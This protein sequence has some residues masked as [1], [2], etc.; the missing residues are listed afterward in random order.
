M[1]ALRH[2]LRPLA[3]LFLAVFAFS[4]LSYA[5]VTFYNNQATWSANTTDVTNRDFNNINNGSFLGSGYSNN[6]VTFYESNNYLFTYG[7]INIGT[8]GDYL[9]TGAWPGIFTTVL[10]TPA[11]AFGVDLALDDS[12]LNQFSAGYYPHTLAVTVN[13]QNDPSA[14]YTINFSGPAGGPFPQGH[15]FFGVTSNDAITSLTFSVPNLYPQYYCDPRVCYNGL[16]GP[17]LFVDNVQTATATT[18]TPEPGSLFLLGSGLLGLGGA[19][20]RKLI[21]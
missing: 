1:S 13:F 5:D 2:V 10:N 3:S 7:Y 18:A 11:S 9:L 21:S 8:G 4:A 19:L 17:Q 12:T 16:G 6:G 20:R 14:S 15:D